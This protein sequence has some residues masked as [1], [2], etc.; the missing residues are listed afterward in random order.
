[1]S[2]ARP[3]TA[4]LAA[5]VVLLSGCGDTP[6]LPETVTSLAATPAVV[7]ALPGDT[8]RIRFTDD[9]GRPVQ[10]T[11]LG[12]SSTAATIDAAGLVTAVTPGSAVVTVS[13]VSGG[14]TVTAAVPVRVLGLTL[15][16]LRVLLTIG[17]VTA[18]RPLFAG[19]SA[20][21][22]TLAWSSSDSTVAR[23]GADGR[24]SGVQPGVARI[25]TVASVDA[26]LRAAVDVAVL[27]S[28]GLIQTITASPATLAL[29]V[30]GTQQI[31]ATVTLSPCAPATESRAALYASSDTGVVTVSAAGLVTAR[32]AGS[33]TITVAAAA[34]PAVAVSVRVTV[35]SPAH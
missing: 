22:G 31:T 6:V 10:P 30:G 26:R 35:G 1:M 18:L 3:T 19:D 21:Y 8:V 7:T 14:R 15:D 20:V 5:L 34:A 2:C 11:V 27:C 17:S 23:V 4:T 16:P 24:V 25:T 32:R 29:P 28:I 12:A 33:A 9:R 13:I